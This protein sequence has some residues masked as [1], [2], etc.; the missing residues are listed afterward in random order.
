MK[1]YMNR[2]QYQFQARR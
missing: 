1:Q 2:V